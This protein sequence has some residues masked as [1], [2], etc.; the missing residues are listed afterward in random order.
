MSEGVTVPAAEA[1]DQESA[2]LRRAGVHVERALAVLF[3]RDVALS[4]AL[5]VEMIRELSKWKLPIEVPEDDPYESPE[6][7]IEAIEDAIA[8][9][10]A[11]DKRAIAA[12]LN[13]Q[14]TDAW[15]AQMQR[16]FSPNGCG[17]HGGEG[18]G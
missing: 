12:W 6:E 8:G 3:A 4:G 14:M 15:D 1:V 11:D 13:L 18:Q 16:D 17:H 10:P 7:A 2:G 5:D 9:L